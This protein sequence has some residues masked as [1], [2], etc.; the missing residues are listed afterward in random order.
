MVVDGKIRKLVDPI[1]FV[2]VY[3]MTDP[4]SNLNIN[5]VEYLTVAKF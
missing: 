2:A 5:L 4:D 3:G 1:N